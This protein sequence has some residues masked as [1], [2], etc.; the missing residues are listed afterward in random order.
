MRRDAAAKQAT[1]ALLAFEN[2]VARPVGQSLDM[3]ER[4]SVELGRLNRIEQAPARQASLEQYGRGM[5]ADYSHGRRLCR[6]ADDALQTPRQAVFVR[7]LVEA[8]LDSKA[9]GGGV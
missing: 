2:S 6:E 9:V 1:I 8:G 4:L 7:V 3:V 5:M